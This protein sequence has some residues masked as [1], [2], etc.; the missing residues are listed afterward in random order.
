VQPSGSTSH[1]MDGTPSVAGLEQPLLLARDK[2]F[3]RRVSLWEPDA[4]ESDILMSLYRYWESLRPEGLLPKRGDFDI[5][6][7]RPVLGM[8]CVVDV[9]ADDP[10]DYFVRLFGS[11]IPLGTDMS[12]HRVGDYPS[13]P[14]REMLAQDYRTAREI[15]APLYHE[16]AAM[17]DF[18]RHS[19]ARLVLPFA[20]DG[21]NVNQL[22]VSSIHQKFPDLLQLLV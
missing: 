12:R 2:V 5:Q 19:Y 9:T 7:L 15:G 17:I 14:Y 21:R 11:E 22:I 3:R 18:K 1:S 20:E 13:L 8:T 10:D 16:I 4:P 6:R